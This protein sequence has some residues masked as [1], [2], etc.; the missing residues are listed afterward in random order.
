MK[1]YG[2]AFRAVCLCFVP[3]DFDWVKT[4]EAWRS[5]TRVEA[6]PPRH[7]STL[8]MSSAHSVGRSPKKGTPGVA[9]GQLV[10]PKTKSADPRVNGSSSGSTPGPFSCKRQFRQ[11]FADRRVSCGDVSPGRATTAASVHAS[12]SVPAW[13]KLSIVSVAPTV[14]VARSF[15]PVG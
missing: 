15:G 10:F 5:P 6:C 11:R 8:Q 9:P 12:K 2:L 13:P 14:R 1:K 4:A 3:T 7:L